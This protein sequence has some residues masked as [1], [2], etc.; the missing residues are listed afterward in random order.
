MAKMGVFFGSAVAS[1]AT[2]TGR[3]TA[4]R[5]APAATRR[6][7]IVE[8]RMT[9]AGSIA[10]ADI[11]H[12]CTLGACTAAGAGTLTAQTPQPMDQGAQAAGSTCGVNAT[13]EPTTYS[14]VL[15]ISFGFNQRGGDR[16]AVP[17]GEGYIFGAENTN[18]VAGVR[19]VSSSAGNIDGDAHFWEP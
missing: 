11:Q 12:E 3:K 2:T 14:A 1:F 9:G 4:L 15:P 7:E 8:I 6:V 5:I 17:R 16:W 10:P 19:I 18:L 13:A